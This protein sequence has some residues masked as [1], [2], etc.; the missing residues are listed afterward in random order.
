MDEVAQ[1]VTLG[2]ACRNTANIKVRQALSTLYVK[3][4]KLSEACAA[5]IRDELNVERVEFIDDARAFTSYQIKPQMRTLG[6]KYG[7]L[8][9]KIGAYLKEVDGNSFVDALEKDGSVKFELD[10]APVELTADDCLIS[11]AQKPGFV[12]E[13]EKDMTVVIDTNLTPELIEKGFVREVISK[14]QTMRKEAGFDVVDRISVTY[15]ASDALAPV[16]AKNADAIAAA[17]LATAIQEADAPEG[18]YAKDW[19]INGE[20]AALSVKKNR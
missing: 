5:L 12:A 4:S 1:A 17:T 6:P 10:G 11:P 3:G 19:N 15:R 2:R 18:A 16:I 13:T 14:L 20:K 8:L 9:G 7:K